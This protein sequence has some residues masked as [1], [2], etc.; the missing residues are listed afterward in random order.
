MLQETF[1]GEGKCP[2]DQYLKKHQLYACHSSYLAFNFHFNLVEETVLFLCRAPKCCS[3][4]LGF[5]K[6]FEVIQARRKVTG[7]GQKLL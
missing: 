3:Y 5:K 4:V 7:R 6:M 1:Q 2:M